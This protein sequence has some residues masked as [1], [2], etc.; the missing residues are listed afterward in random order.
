MGTSDSGRVVVGVSDSITGLAALRTAVAEARRRRLPIH[1]VRAWSMGGSWAAAGLSY[2]REDQA[3]ATAEMTVRAF[4]AALGAMPT[5]VRVVTVTIEGTPAAALVAYADR[6][7]DLLVLGAS[8]RVGL[9]R[10][11]GR[12]VAQQCVA[13]AVCPV[14]AVPPNTLARSAHRLTR[15]LRRDMAHL[16]A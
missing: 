13:R 2:L 16:V 1:A 9:R 5:D 12:S 6:D 8:D 7:G 15:Q 14:L 3:R 10:L 11:R 4:G